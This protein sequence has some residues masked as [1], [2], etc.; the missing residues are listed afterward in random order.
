M[1]EAAVTKG[2]TISL[3]IVIRPSGDKQVTVDFYTTFGD[4]LDAQKLPPGVSVSIQPSTV[5]LQP[6]K[7]SMIN[8]VVQVDKN[9]PDGT[10]M[11][12]IVGKWG[13]PDD[14][15]GSAVSLKIGNGTPKFVFSG[16]IGQ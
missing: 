16:G 12:N 3:P 9:A 10:Y 2:T 4:Q 5:I 13:G 8:L 7:D 1:P 14:F 15:L 6:G 11:Q